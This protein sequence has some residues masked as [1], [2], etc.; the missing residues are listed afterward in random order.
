MR[1]VGGRSRGGWSAFV[2]ATSAVTYVVISSCVGDPPDVAIRGDAAGF[3]APQADAPPADGPASDAADA[4]D[5]RTF[6]Q[7][8]AAGAICLDFELGSPQMLAWKTD[9]RV[10]GGDGGIDVVFGE[11]GSGEGGS[12]FGRARLP[13]HDGG[14]ATARYTRLVDAGGA[15]NVWQVE[16]DL[17]VGARA[18]PMDD[19]TVL[20]FNFDGINASVPLTVNLN[21]PDEGQVYAVNTADAALFSL[22]FPLGA[23]VWHHVRVRIERDQGTTTSIVTL[24]GT[25][26]SRLMSLPIP[27]ATNRIVVGLTA[28]KRIGPVVLD[29]DNALF[30]TE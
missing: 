26:V 24:D 27:Q 6:C 20:I 22:P 5:E 8:Q 13:A 12:A 16:M 19:T 7:R 30:T 23:G 4:S 25:E 3:D 14:T 2:A 10:D 18:I 21:G 15:T 28:S 9:V 17:R 1:R 29:V 11:G